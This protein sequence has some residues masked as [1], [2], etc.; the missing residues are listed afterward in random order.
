MLELLCCV[1]VAAPA[2]SHIVPKLAKRI[3]CIFTA[4]IQHSHFP[5]SSAKVLK[6]GKKESKKFVKIGAAVSGCHAVRRQI[7][8][9]LSSCTHQYNQAR[10]C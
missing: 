6:K 10:Q 8:F 9:L 2:A 1:M 4:S 3:I 5:C 7:V